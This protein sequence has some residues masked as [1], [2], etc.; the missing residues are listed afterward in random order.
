[1]LN[2]KYHA[3]LKLKAAKKKDLVSLCEKGLMLGAEEFYRNLPEYGN[4]A[5]PAAAVN[6]SDDDGDDYLY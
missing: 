5:T 3:P 2:R 4:E 1:T 6:D